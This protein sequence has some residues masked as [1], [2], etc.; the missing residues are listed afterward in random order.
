M[1]GLI[2]L[3]EAQ[4]ERVRTLRSDAKL[5]IFA[6]SGHSPFYK[7]APS[8]RKPSATIASLPRFSLS[9]TGLRP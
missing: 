6:D 9:N 1:D 5:S 4:T 8:P 7:T 3:S 2:W